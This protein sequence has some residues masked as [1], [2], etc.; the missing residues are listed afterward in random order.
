MYVHFKVMRKSTFT[1]SFH[2]IKTG[3]HSPNATQ[4]HN[5]VTQL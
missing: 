4:S 3:L 5:Y 2:Q 1:F